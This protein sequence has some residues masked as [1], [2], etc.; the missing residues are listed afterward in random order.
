MTT[1]EYMR[2]YRERRKSGFGPFVACKCG[3]GK[4]FRKYDGHNKKARRFVAGHNGRGRPRSA[5]AR[6]KFSATIR[7]RNAE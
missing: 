6:A 1:A 7:K 4:R 5:E 2:E 3:C